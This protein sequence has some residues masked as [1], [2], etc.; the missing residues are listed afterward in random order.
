MKPRYHTHPRY[1][2]YPAGHVSIRGI[3]E[4]RYTVVDVTRVGQPGGE[5]KV[6]EEVELSRALFEVSTYHRLTNHH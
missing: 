4:E 6:L 3:E 1:M 2:P 5:A